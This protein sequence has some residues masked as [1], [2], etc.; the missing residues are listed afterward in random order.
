MEFY[1]ANGNKKYCTDGGPEHNCK[2]RACY[3][4]LKN[5]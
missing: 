1:L 5:A 4:R 2:S 3:T